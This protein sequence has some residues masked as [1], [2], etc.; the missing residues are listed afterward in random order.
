MASSNFNADS[1]NAIIRM[2]LF[3]RV[4]YTKCLICLYEL[5]SRGNAKTKECGAKWRVYVASWQGTSHPMK[6]YCQL[7][8][9]SMQLKTDPSSIESQH[10]DTLAAFGSRLVRYL[11]PQGQLQQSQNPDGSSETVTKNVG[12][13]CWDPQ[14]LPTS[15][16]HDTLIEGFGILWKDTEEMLEG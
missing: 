1:C 6:S 15:A 3:K 13:R 12:W 5:W 9:C 2:F 8:L 11:K 10:Y 14:V 16:R 7:S 4:G